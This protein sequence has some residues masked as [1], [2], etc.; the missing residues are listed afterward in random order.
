VLELDEEQGVVR[1]CVIAQH[2]EAEP[3]SRHGQ[4]LTTNVMEDEHDKREGEMEIDLSNL[5][6]VRVSN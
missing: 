1:V 5:E 2:E 4:A 3:V 6:D